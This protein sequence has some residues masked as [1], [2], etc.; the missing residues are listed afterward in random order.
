[1]VQQLAQSCGPSPA[2]RAFGELFIGPW[3]A[4]LKPRVI[5]VIVPGLY[6]EPRMVKPVS[7]CYNSPTS[8]RS[9]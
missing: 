4:I 7:R 9:Q 5:K 1:M 6:L 2:C 3:I 8:G